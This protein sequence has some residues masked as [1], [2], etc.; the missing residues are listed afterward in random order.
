[1]FG[2]LCLFSLKK[3]VPSD[4]LCDLFEGEFQLGQWDL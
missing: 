3:A 2:K 1:M 4:E